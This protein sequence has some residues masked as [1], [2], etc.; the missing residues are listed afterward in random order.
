M[1]SVAPSHTIA[2]LE[3]EVPRPSALRLT[4]AAVWTLWQRDMRRFFRQPSRIIGALAQP[5]IFWLVIGSGFS[6]SFKLSGAEGLGYL[7]YFFPG[8]LL[9]LVLFSSI[10]STM[11]VIEDR[12]AG[13]LQAVLV[14]PAPRL[15]LV[16]GKTLGGTSV[17]L[18]QAALILPLAGWAGFPLGGVHWLTAL[19]ILTGAGMALT[20]LGFALA[21][22]LDSTQGYHAIMSVLLLPMWILSGAM[23]PPGGGHSA[24]ISRVMV[25]N[26]LSYTVLGLRRALYGG[27]LPAALGGAGE[28]RELLVTLGFLV[29]AVALAALAVSAPTRRTRRA[30]K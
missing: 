26:P 12:H 10:F 11:S 1:A 29:G 13:F 9:M 25:W 14:A 27:H 18:I 6:S 30:S 20:A 5:L 19:A 7:E 15:A 3:T 21:W 8:I 23:F 24:W 28:A 16:L 2:A 22:A 4:W 17:A